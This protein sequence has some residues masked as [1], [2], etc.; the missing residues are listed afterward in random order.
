MST[1]AA[2][3]DRV[4]ELVGLA[5]PA[6][7]VKFRAFRN[8]MAFDAWAVANPAACLRRFQVR[9]TVADPIG[10]SNDLTD[11]RWITITCTVAY[12][13]SG[14]Q[15]S[16]GALDRDDTIDADYS[17]INLAIG[18]SAASAFESVAATPMGCSKSILRLQGV[19]LLIVTER[20]RY[21]RAM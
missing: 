2:I 8:E 9:S 4:A 13:Q 14:R 6:S 16:A 11:E 15:G 17:A 12:P 20:F 21:R 18:Q 3:R 5:A 7:D 19:D 10:Q 1:A